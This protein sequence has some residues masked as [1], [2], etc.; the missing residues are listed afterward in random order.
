MRTM[1]FT[2]RRICGA[3]I[4][5][6]TLFFCVGVFVLPANAA[7]ESTGKTIYVV[8]DDSGSMC[9]N[10]LPR[11][12]QAKYAMEVFAAMLGE[13]DTMS[14]YELSGGGS[15][16]LTISGKDQS[17]VE[18]VHQ[19]NSTFRG[20][21]YAPVERAA[22]ELSAVPEERERWF[23]VLTDGTFDGLRERS[24]EWLEGQMDTLNQQG[25]KTVFLGIGEKAPVLSSNAEQ[26]RYAE[27]AVSGADVIQKVTDIANQIF[28]HQVMGGSYLNKQGNEYQ[29]TCDVPISEIVVFAQGEDAAVGST[30]TYNEQTVRASESYQVKYSDLLP[31][32]Y[33]DAVVDASLVGNVT[34]FKAPQSAPFESGSF[35]I[36]AQGSQEVQIYYRPSVTV[37]CDMLYNGMPINPEDKLYAGEYE[38]RLDFVDPATGDVLNSNLLKDAR[39]SL[40][41]WNNGEYQEVTN[42][43][44]KVYLNEGDITLQAIAALPGNITLRNEREYVVLPEPVTLGISSDADAKSYTTIGLGEKAVPIIL[45]VTNAATGE[46]LTEEQWNNATVSIAKASGVEWLIT[47]GQQV[48]TWEARPAKTEGLLKKVKTGTTTFE[49]SAE[50]QVGRACGYGGSKMEVTISEYAGSDLRIELTPPGQNYDIASLKDAPGISARITYQ[51]PYTGEYLPL[52]E[53]Q[54]NSLKLSASSDH[55]IG[56]RVEKGQEPGTWTLYPTWYLGIRVLTGKLFTDQITV[57]LSVAASG[58]AENLK[59]KGAAQ[60]ELTFLCLPWSKVWPDLLIAALVL[61]FAVWLILGYIRKP[62]IIPRKMN[63]RCVYNTTVSPRRTIRKKFLRSLLPYLPDRAVVYSNATTYACDFPSLKIQAVDNYSFKILNN[64]M[65]WDHTMISNVMLPNAETLHKR[66][67]YYNNFKIAS[68]DHRTQLTRGYFTFNYPKKKK[69]RIVK[70]TKYRR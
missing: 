61:A 10:G 55:R 65:D 63:P 67:Y 49:V 4:L 24:A 7:Q 69:R 50:Y 35:T 59:F 66:T 56:W 2:F 57:T 54:W 19:M 44:G 38:I 37:T 48:S 52:T 53:E 68:I 25:I 46:P 23:V 18:M 21:P 14:I 27:K 8:Y 42:K 64:S 28:E 16:A 26:G 47:K 20:T 13:N 11:W 1:P 39:F 9:M 30:M 31:E 51:D 22:Q 29:L 6:L 34:I 62:R 15:V 17:R 33:P 40:K 43:N 58:H 41:V 32:N 45:T 36:Q 3:L 70:T 60:Q 5:T 12:S